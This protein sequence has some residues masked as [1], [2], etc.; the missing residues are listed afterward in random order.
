M[1][2]LKKEIELQRKVLDELE[3]KLNQLEKEKF[4]ETVDSLVEEYCKKWNGEPDYTL[5]VVGELALYAR[6]DKVTDVDKKIIIQGHRF[7][8]STQV[9]YES[10]RREICFILQCYADKYNE[11]KIDWSNGRQEKFTIGYN[12]MFD[13]IDNY[14]S[15]IYQEPYSIYFDDEDTLNKAIALIGKEN[16]IKYYFGV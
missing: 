4:V 14:S 15:F 13:R 10:K 9:F 12:H 1:N 11:C 6:V 7:K 2:E 5:N 16:I 3:T 8:N